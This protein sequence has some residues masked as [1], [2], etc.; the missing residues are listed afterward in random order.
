MGH[1]A[2]LA[3]A[4][5]GSVAIHAMFDAANVLAYT[6]PT[7]IAELIAG[8]AEIYVKQPAHQRSAPISQALRFV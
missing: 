7:T 1:N 8:A 3:A 2:H 6:D 4:D 5:S